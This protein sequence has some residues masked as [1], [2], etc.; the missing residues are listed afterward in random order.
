LCGLWL[1]LWGKEFNA[2]MS[3]FFAKVNYFLE[4]DVTFAKFYVFF[5]CLLYN[6]MNLNY[7]SILEFLLTLVVV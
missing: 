3:E 7:N 5:Y 2:A 1:A 4:K 6:L